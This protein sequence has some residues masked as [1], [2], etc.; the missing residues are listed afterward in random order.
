MQW[1]NKILAVRKNT[2]QIQITS[3]LELTEKKRR[4]LLTGNVVACKKKASNNRN[5]GKGKL[6]WGV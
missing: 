2:T 6:S 4:F 1:S 5:S 3:R